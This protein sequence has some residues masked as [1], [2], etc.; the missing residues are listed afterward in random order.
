MT[1]NDE[2]VGR[3]RAAS[4][5]PQYLTDVLSVFACSRSSGEQLHAYLLD[6]RDVHWSSGTRSVDCV[7]RHN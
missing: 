5:L 4:R 2:F 3:L 7:I 1:D 6:H